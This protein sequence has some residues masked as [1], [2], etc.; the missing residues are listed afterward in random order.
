M[1]VH[2][3]GS[4]GVGHWRGVVTTRSLGV[5]FGAALLA[6]AAPGPAAAHLRTGTAAVDYRAAV[7]DGATAAYTARIYQSDRAIALSVEQ[8]HTVVVVGYLG[9][10]MLRLS[11]AGLAVNTASPT[12]A[13]AGLLARG[14]RVL[15]RGAAWRLTRGRRSAVWHDARA[16]GLPAGTSRGTWRIPLEVDGHRVL[17]TGTLRRL[18]RPA[19]WPWAFLFAI[20]VLGSGL[21][22]RRLP[23]TALGRAAIATAVVAGLAAVET[24]LAFAVDAYASP[25]T[26]IAGMDELAL[27]AAAFAALV[28]APR[29]AHVPVAVCLGLLSAAVALSKGAAFVHAVVLAA[30]PGAARLMLTL[31]LGCGFAAALLGSVAYVHAS[32]RREALHRQIA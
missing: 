20:F 8:G 5:A 21:A 26:W 6:L 16:A 1:S 30:A 31:A 23:A 11:A 14:E 12:A 10:P 4:A 32:S 22:S 13:S 28:W 24:A 3:H 15:A 18:R 7:T 25:G 2:R 9:E 27:V 17:L 29:Q 19:L